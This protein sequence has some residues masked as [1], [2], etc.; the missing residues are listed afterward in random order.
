MHAGRRGNNNFS[1]PRTR[2]IGLPCVLF[3]KL[4]IMAVIS[5]PQGRK[6][7]FPYKEAPSFGIPKPPPVKNAKSKTPP[8][9][10]LSGQ[11]LLSRPRPEF[12]L[13]PYALRTCM[14]RGPKLVRVTSQNYTKKS[15]QRNK[16]KKKRPRDLL[17][18]NDGLEPPTCRL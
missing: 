5:P 16:G 13:N 14:T 10:S 1:H 4:N 11:T 18:G 17:V 6:V 8:R 2:E 15:P 9:A 7:S 12:S 3:S